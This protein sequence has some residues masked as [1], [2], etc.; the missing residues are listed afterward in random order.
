MKKII[1]AALLFTSVSS[2][3]SSDKVATSNVIIKKDPVSA[4]P[5]AVMVSFNARFPNAGNVTWSIQSTPSMIIYVADFIVGKTPA[6]ETHVRAMFTVD[7]KFLGKEFIY[8]PK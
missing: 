4:V 8:E 3:A 6:T 5:K 2:F 1:L 7:G